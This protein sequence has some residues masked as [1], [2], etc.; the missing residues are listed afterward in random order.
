MTRTEFAG[1]VDMVELAPATTREEVKALVEDACRFHFHSLGCPY[2]YHPYAAALLKEKG[3]GKTVMLLGG[4]GF[5]DGNWPTQVKLNSIALC[6]QTGCGEIDLTS[7]LGWIKSGMWQEYGEEIRQA[8]SLARGVPLKVIIH[9]PQLTDPELER[10]CGILLENGADY[11]KTDTG[12]SP[13]PTS[14]EQVRR[15]REIVGDKMRI[16]ASGGIRRAEDAK[17]MK[18]A[19]A[20]R[21]G[22]RH[23]AAMQIWK[24]LADL[25]AA[26]A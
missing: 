1:M 6:L 4:G 2:C 21:L 25:D 12:R 7:N 19:G 15:I 11:V 20:D 10:A 22:I 5:A 8:R 23:G 14:P 24:E 17:R 9:A 16:K 26:G 3:C 13:Q 18:E